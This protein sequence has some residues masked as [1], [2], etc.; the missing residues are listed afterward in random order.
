LKLKEIKSIKQKCKYKII[1]SYHKWF[2]KIKIIIIYKK[3]YYFATFETSQKCPNFI[4]PKKFWK[5]ISQDHKKN[6]GKEIFEKY[7]FL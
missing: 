7:I 6:Y 3:Y 5:N 2:Y 1:I 4:F